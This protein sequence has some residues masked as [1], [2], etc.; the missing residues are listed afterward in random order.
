MCQ[1]CRAISKGKSRR[2]LAEYRGGIDKRHSITNTPVIPHFIRY[3][4]QGQAVKDDKM[5]EE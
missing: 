2:L 5:R 4:G 3:A 1:E